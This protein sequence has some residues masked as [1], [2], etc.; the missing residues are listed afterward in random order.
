MVLM[1][2]SKKARYESS[3]TNQNQGGGDKKA[4]LPPTMRMTSARWIGFKNRGLP[5]AMSV[6]K[7]PLVSTVRQSRPVTVRP[8][9]WIGMGGNY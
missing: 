3:I 7:L 2:G 8:E 5:K 6:M 1:N 4:G 9:N